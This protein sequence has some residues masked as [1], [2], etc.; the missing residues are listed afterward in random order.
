MFGSVWSAAICGVNCV[1]V[2]VEA[3]VSNGLPMFTM[4][5]YLSSQV[6]EAQERVRIAVRNAGISLPPKRITVNLAPADVRKEGNR[7][8]LPIAAALLAAFGYIEKERL[9]HVM[10]A[11][12]L[13]LDGSVNPVRGIL[14]LTEAAA[15][16]GCGLC[17]VPAGNYREALMAGHCKVLGVKSLTELLERASREDWGYE[18]PDGEGESII[19]KTQAYNYPVDFADIRGQESV[20]RAA[21]IAAAGFHN[22]LMSGRKGAGKTMI[23]R[24]IPTIMPRL[25]R[26]ECLEISRLYSVAGLLS[27]EQPFLTERPFRA[28]HHTASAQA[29]AGG[30]RYPKPGEITLSHR[31]VLFL[32]EFPEFS[33]SAVEILR[34]PLE[35]HRILIARTGGVFE[36]PAHFMLVA[37]MNHCPCGNY[38]DMKRCTCTAGQIQHYQSRISG[39]VLDRIDMCVEVDNVNYGEL[40]KGKMGKSSAE[41]LTQVE[42][43]RGIQ[44][45]RYKDMGIRFNS[46]LGGSQLQRCCVPSL[47]GRRILEKVY[48]K[49][50]LSARAYHKILKTA[51]TIADLD[52]EEEIKEAHISEAVCYRSLEEAG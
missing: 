33:H 6:K 22:I 15:R 10:M 52:G 16:H 3:D 26:E 32:D 14:P 31:G 21:V 4:V 42:K 12:E 35:E 40:T 11:G 46:E 9:V 19:S 1:P 28:P 43:V 37:A 39:P 36:F 30:G 7:F 8:D 50:N 29:M 48:K 45:E 24:R 49:M 25:D 23:A 44:E 38:P 2:R 51:R 34:Q 18:A 20:K 13:S 5:G 41:Y 17:I 27:D 47:E